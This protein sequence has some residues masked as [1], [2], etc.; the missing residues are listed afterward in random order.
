MTSDVNQ[1]LKTGQVI[2]DFVQKKK[3][4]PDCSKESCS[5]STWAVRPGKNPLGNTSD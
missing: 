5:K 1:V 2:T 3:L 4:N